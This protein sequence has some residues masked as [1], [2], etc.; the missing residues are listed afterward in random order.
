[1]PDELRRPL[2]PSTASVYDISVTIKHSEQCLKQNI[3]LLFLDNLTIWYN[4]TFIICTN[5][6]L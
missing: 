2:E 5:L 6:L 3:I 4:R 1:M